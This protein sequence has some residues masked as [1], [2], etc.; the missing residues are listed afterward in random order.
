MSSASYRGCTSVVQLLLDAGANP[1]IPAGN[2][3]PLSHAMS[4]GHTFTVA[5]LR[6]ALA[7]PDRARALH[8]ALA[9]LEA[10]HTIRKA[11]LGDIHDDEQQQHRRM[12]TRGDNKRQAITAAPDYL[13]DR[14]ERDEPLSQVNLM[15]Q[16]AD[17]Q[18]HATVAFAVGLEG[19][20]SEEDKHLP[21]ELFKELLGYIMYE[22]ADKGAEAAA[23]E[24]DDE[25]A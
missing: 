10:A 14:V 16:Q 7:E 21:R 19:D 15:P 5:L 12:R 11:R 2:R 23:V 4:R 13:K 25:E 3:L 17:E 9:L 24:E 18:L 6:H 8:K 20:G 22:W 1:T